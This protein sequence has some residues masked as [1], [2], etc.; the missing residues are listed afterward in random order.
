MKRSAIGIALILTAAA[1]V[2]GQVVLPPGAGSPANITAVHGSVVTGIVP[3]GAGGPGNVTVAHGTII[4][5]IL[6][7]GAT[8]QPNRGTALPK[9]NQA[10]GVGPLPGNPLPPEATTVQGGNFIAIPATPA[11][12]GQTPGPQTPATNVPPPGT[13]PISSTETVPITSAETTADGQAPDAA[14]SSDVAP[15][16]G[17]N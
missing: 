14:A 11:P 15:A 13:V 6:P 2:H 17:S 12:I 7:P 8:L 16:D 3:P 4:T 9:P 5:G 1:M 10:A